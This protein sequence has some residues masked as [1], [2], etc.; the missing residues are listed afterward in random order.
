[1]SAEHEQEVADAYRVAGLDRAHFERIL[2]L[3]E[4]I[5]A[6]PWTFRRSTD[7]SGVLIL[8]DGDE[9]LAVIDAGVD[10]AK[11]LVAVSPYALFGR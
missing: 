4:H 10:F 9:P 1:M 8:W 3:A 6:G 11:Y 2:E 7:G 5:P